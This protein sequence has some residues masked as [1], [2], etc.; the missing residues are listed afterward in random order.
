MC[1]FKNYKTHLHALLTRIQRTRRNSECRFHR[2]AAW[3]SVC[4]SSQTL[5]ALSPTTLPC[6][7]MRVHTYALRDISCLSHQSACS[8]GPR[9]VSAASV[10]EP[11]IGLTNIVP[12][13][14]GAGRAL[15]PSFVPPRPMQAIAAPSTLRFREGTNRHIQPVAPATKP[16]G[17]GSG[18]PQRQTWKGQVAKLG[19]QQVL[20]PQRQTGPSA[21]QKLGKNRKS[22]SSLPQGTAPRQSDSTHLELSW[23]G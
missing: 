18:F 21:L 2:G 7:C 14:G 16:W 13:R 15:A 9:A 4:A 1:C 11:G 3:D 6:V 23:G 8:L 5:P 20:L 12:F 17:L 22:S 10:G 19:R